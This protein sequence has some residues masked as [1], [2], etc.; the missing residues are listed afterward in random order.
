MA[1]Q[2]ALKKEPER[3]GRAVVSAEGKL[4]SVSDDERE[5]APHQKFER[6]IHERSRLGIISALAVNETL[7]FNDLKRL[8]RTTDGNLSVHAR[9][10]ED[11]GYIACTKSFEGRTPK[12][13]YQLTKTGRSALEQYLN[14]MEALIKTMRPPS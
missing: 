10:L 1:R 9:K 5:S 12:T 2:N 7:T 13:E 4:K 14:H 6:L 8:V 11:A 3:K